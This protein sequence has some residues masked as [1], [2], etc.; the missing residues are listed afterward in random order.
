MI[1]SGGN[2]RPKRLE[3]LI[4]GRLIARLDR[5][6]YRTRRIF[7]GRLQG[8]RR[9]KRRGQSVEF[10]D[11]R[12]YV[13]GD[14][15]RHIDWNVYARFDRLF[16]KLFLEEEDLSVHIALDASPSMEAGSPAKLLFAARLALAL[17]CI[18]LA[19]NNRVGVSVF[20]APMAGGMSEGSPVGAPAAGVVRLPELRGRH[21]LQ[22]IAR[23]LLDSAWAEGGRNAPA[24][25]G[26]A[27][28]D[29]LTA[30]ARRRTGKGVMLVISDFLVP[31][32]PDEPER[33]GYE[34]GL[35]ALAAAGGYDTCCLQIL[36]PGEVEPELEIKADGGDGDL[37]LTDIETGRAA[38]VT[39][40][41]AMLRKYK[42][43]LEGYCAALHAFC[44]ARAMTHILAR[45]D[46]DLEPL[47]LDT[48]R[49]RGL[50][51]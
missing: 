10:D 14:D 35:R 4:D 51:G 44:A 23:F 49:R 34:R 2:E 28:S 32:E 12:D 15:L 19:G 36:S 16:I 21:H 43:R 47:L 29:S 37:R 38:E 25:A 48:L 9:S 22:R 27:F 50:V 6:D 8:E 31:P 33:P 17:A 3:D 26:A 13:P 7:A 18:G 39:I 5:L 20:G 40:T 30:I 41:A 45:S 24:A 46:A 11:Y 1:I 42:E